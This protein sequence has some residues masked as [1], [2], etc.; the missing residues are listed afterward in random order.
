MTAAL[1]AAAVWLNIATAVGAP[2]STTHSIIGA[3]LGAGLAAG[4]TDAANWDKLGGI[5]ASWV[6]SPLLGGLIAA[7][8]LYWIKRQITW[9]ADMLK[10]AR[11]DVPLLIGVMVFAFSAYLVLKG[12]EQDLGSK[13]AAGDRPSA[14][15][16]V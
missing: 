9:Q 14:C 7:G 11:R 10:A 15:C 16:S 3:V 13:H 12:S 1:L 8:F 4:G 5:A 6:I 2:V